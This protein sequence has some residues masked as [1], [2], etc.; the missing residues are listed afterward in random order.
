[1]GDVTSKR[2]NIYIDQT[3]AETALEKLQVKA[4]GFNKKIDEGRTKQK[5]L[6]DE[7]VKAA[8]AGKSTDKLTD[9]YKSLEKQITATTK[10][11]AT[12]TEAQKKLQT[13]IDSGIRPSLVQ[14][15]N[16]VKSLRNQLINLSQDA[17]GYAEKFQAFRKATTTLDTMKAS[18]N[19]VEKAQTSWLKQAGTIGFGVV[20]GNTIQ[21]AL[22]AIGNYVSGIVTGNA[23]TSDSLA[24]LQRVT[25]LTAKEVSNLNTQLKSID[26][27]TSLSGLRDIAIIAG[28]LGVAKNDILGFTEAV[29]KLVVALGDELGDAGQITTDLGKIL[30]VFEGKITGE[31]ITFLGN[32]IVDLANKG[33]ASGPFLVDFTQRVSGIAKTANLSLSSVLGLAAGLE[34]SG[35]KV[36]SS[37]TAVQKLITAIAEDLPAAA[38]IAGEPVDK[39]NQLFADKPQEALLLYAQGLQKNKGSFA[40]VA[41]SFKDAGEDGTRTIAVLATLGQK[42]DFFRQKMDEAGAAIQNTDQIQNAFTLK[43]NTLGAQLDKLSKSFSSLIQS[44]TLTDFF[45]SAISGLNNFI[46]ALKAAPQWIKENSTGITL[47]ITGLVL[48]NASYITSGASIIRDTALK[49]INAA[50]TRLTALATNIAI[51][52]QGAYIVIT[53]LLTARITL[54]VAAQRLWN[55]AISLG[56]GPIG[57]IIVAAG[58]LTIGLS[59]LLGATKQL[60]VAQQINNQVQQEMAETVGAEKETITNLLSIAQDLTLDYEA[61]K[62][63]L[64]ELIRQNPEYLGGLNLE[65]I[66]TQQGVDI[67]NDYIDS[68]DRLSKA[69]ALAGLKDKLAQQRLEQDVNNKVL[70]QNAKNEGFLSN[71]FLTPFGAS[72]NA[73]YTKALKEN[74]NTLDQFIEVNKETKEAVSDLN[75]KIEVQTTQLGKLKKGT[76]EYI[77]TQRLLNSYRK[78][79]NVYL[80]LPT[81]TGTGNTPTKPTS[82]GNDD[83]TAKELAAAAKEASKAKKDLEELQKAWESLLG[84]IM[85]KNQTPLSEE[86]KALKEFDTDLQSLLSSKTK[87]IAAGIFNQ[88]EFDKAFEKISGDYKDKIAKIN[89]DKANKLALPVEIIPNAPEEDDATAMANAIESQKKILE[90][91]K[92]HFKDFLKDVFDKDSILETGKALLGAAQTAL[93]IIDK[94]NQAKNARESRSLDRE[95]KA[96][97]IRKKSNESL[98]S[99]KTITQQELARRNAQID[100]ESDRRKEDLERKQFERNKRQQIAQAGISGAQALLTSVAKFGPPIPPNFEGIIAFAFTLSTSLAEIAAIS[101]AKYAQGGKLSGPSHDQGGMP[102]ISNGRKVAEMEGGEGILKKSAMASRQ[103]YTV[104]GTAS[105]IAS[106]LNAAHGGVQWDNE[107][108]IQPAYRNRPYYSVDY[109]RINSSYS[110]LRYAEGGKFNAGSQNTTNTAQAQDN[111]EM[112]NMLRLMQMHLAQNANTIKVLNETLAAGINANVSL[113]KFDDARALDE[114]RKKDGEFK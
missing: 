81:D 49:V 6:N 99:N 58:A 66:T 55:V 54:A 10:S 9:Q 18:I 92:I 110:S 1:M 82:P 111:S 57:L 46:D 114:R 61:R 29:D 97:D 60:T 74:G 79:R 72:D 32:A 76:D 21:A 28:K 17:P 27:R 41:K 25:G 89:A 8:A 13:Q 31:N 34:E 86:A 44:K 87:L 16:L 47:L 48:L 112:M 20:I 4:D 106:T 85:G 96:N 107:A 108:A 15:G 84:S 71:F 3:A 90:K 38:K 105:E 5:L 68:L 26:T 37:A 69:K 22:A 35:A 104:T 2:V 78:E 94:F 65:N 113:K 7:I 64:D 50:T 24:D 43:N 36:E 77:K 91:L 109:G 101:S 75:F 93:G 62:K 40:E 19:G 67:I 98:A 45:T 14:Q 53:N 52:S 56:A 51:A 70:E 73:K 83:P 12:T 39:F 63:A 33:V 30:N 95:L 102:V 59:N 42:T 100:A 80:G 103:R 23:K 11:L 88:A